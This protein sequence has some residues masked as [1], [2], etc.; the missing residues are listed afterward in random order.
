MLSEPLQNEFVALL[1][2]DRV[3]TDPAT[4]A[5]YASDETPKSC[6]PEA[7]LF[8]AS[9]DHVAGIV[10]IAGRA[11]LPITPRG[12]GSGN[13]GGALPTPG[14]LVVSFECMN[15]VLE[16]D[17]DNRL[18]VVQPGVVTDDID[19]LAASAGLMYAPDPGSGAYSRIGGNLAMNAAGPRAVKYGTTR[20][21]VLGLRAVL[22][23]GRE[24]RTGSRTTKY[25]TGYD[26]TRLLVGSEGTLALITEATLRL[27]PAPRR[28]ASLRVC[29][30][31]TRAAC[32]AVIRAMRQP[33]VPYALEFMDGR[34]ID[35][36]REYGAAEGLPAGT[37]AIL[38]VEVEGD[39]EDI[40]RHLAALEA[41]LRGDGL[42]EVQ[43]GFSKAEIAHLWTAR[44]SL[45][46]AVKKIAP[47]KINED[48][49]VP[50]GKLADLV[51]AI[52]DLGRRHRVPVVA[53]GHA[54]NGNL[55]VNIMVHPDDIDE[56][57][58]ARACRLELVRTVLGLSGSLSGEHGIGSEKRPFVGL[59]FEPAT[60]A[61]MRQV[62]ALFDPHGILNPGKKLPD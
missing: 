6:T 28:I 37:Q 20:D 12:A 54:G 58:R 50:V 62:K 42:L 32:E 61:L 47:L 7:V 27:L 33:V 39:D 51:A 11:R 4:L 29:Y 38:M 8:P 56:M 52:D 24:I 16:F 10:A 53:F 15:R 9:H 57:T 21:H 18:M 14:S 60:L 26:L 30:S 5:L 2:A 41:A 31:G 49:V 22:G 48:V 19:E 46:H 36:V 25:A 35:A 45:S 44:K 59:E 23:D 1:G 3:H 17:P 34:S 55:H 40:P 43:S 13:V